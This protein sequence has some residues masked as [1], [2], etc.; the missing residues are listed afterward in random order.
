MN[1][2]INLK[3]AAAK[4]QKDIKALERRIILCAGTGLCCQRR[5][6]SA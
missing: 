4:Y 2:T 1:K 6:E 3:A 5:S